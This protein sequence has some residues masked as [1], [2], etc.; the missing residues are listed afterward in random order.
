VRLELF[1]LHTVEVVQAVG[2]RAAQNETGHG[3]VRAVL[4]A[5]ARCRSSSRVVVAI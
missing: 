4:V 2:T 3:G 5:V 1:A